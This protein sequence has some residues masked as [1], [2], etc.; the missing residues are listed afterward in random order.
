[1]AILI[2]FFFFYKEID[3]CPSRNYDDTGAKELK[4][5]M[6]KNNLTDI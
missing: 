3:R 5:I 6:T 4:T 2:G 1:M